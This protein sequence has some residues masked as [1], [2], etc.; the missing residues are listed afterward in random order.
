MYLN[1]KVKLKSYCLPTDNID[2][3]PSLII[4]IFT[5]KKNNIKHQ[6]I[7]KLSIQFYDFKHS[8]M[9]LY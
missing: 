9:L 6:K 5:R 8:S 2:I 4:F 3:C 7:N 1:I